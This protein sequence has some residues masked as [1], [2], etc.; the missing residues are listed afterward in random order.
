MRMNTDTCKDRAGM[1]PGKIE[2]GMTRRQIGTRVDHTCHTPS[3]SSLNDCFSVG[4]K[5]RGIDVCMA[6]NKHYNVSFPGDK[7]QK[8]GRQ[9]I[10]VSLSPVTPFLYSIAIGMR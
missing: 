2:R 3:N 4:I 10:S 6:I 9:K 5:T 7:R 8:K 1:L